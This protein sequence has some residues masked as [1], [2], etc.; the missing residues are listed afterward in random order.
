MQKILITGISGFLGSYLYASLKEDY[1]IIGTYHNSD[2]PIIAHAVK[3]DLANIQA[4]G[5]WIEQLRP[6]ILIHTAAITSI[7]QCEK[8]EAYTYQVNVAASVEM[9][10][11]AKLCGAK[12]IFCS[13][14]MV[15]DGRRGNYTETDLPN[16]I[17][18]YGQQKAAAEKH[19]IAVNE[20]T[21]IARLPLLIGENKK[22]TAGSIAEMQIKNEQKGTMHLF[23]NEYRTPARVED[24]VQGIL[25]LLQKAAKGI[26]HLSG[27]EKMNRYQIAERIKVKYKLND[28]SLIATTH[29][30]QGCTN[31]P[32]DVSMDNT[33]MRNLG[34]APLDI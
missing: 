25:L 30:E 6:N 16:P 17:N 18:I 12:F 33:K 10:W 24:V 1:K 14:D 26:Y 29:Q 27:T 20:N 19:C 32:V 2:K 8:E 5:N 7:A 22:G 23:T 13:T 15:F 4:V 11:M 28:V 31:R 3:I 21:I 9:A 34:Y